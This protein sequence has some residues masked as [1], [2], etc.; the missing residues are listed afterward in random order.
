MDKRLLDAPKDELKDFL[1][2]RFQMR[3]R[4]AADTGT[5]ESE[6]PDDLPLELWGAAN[7]GLRRRIIQATRELIA[8]VPGEGWTAEAVD[9]LASFVGRAEIF[10]VTGDLQTAVEHGVWLNAPDDGVRCHT[11][12]LWALLGL[13]WKGTP[14]FWRQLSQPVRARYPALALRGL[15]ASSS[16]ADAFDWLPILLCDEAAVHQVLDV[17]SSLTRRVG[18]EVVREHLRAVRL[19]LSSEV[20]AKLDEWFEAYGW[21]SLAVR[22]EPAP[23]EARAPLRFA[24][25]LAE[26]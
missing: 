15:L 1:R 6:F 13:G 19:R 18:T 24:P 8:E 3:G 9:W 2:G 21:G 7:E 5:R 23:P 22:W 26:R 14:E 11:A 12:A 16:L 20:R 25:A 4:W 17:L 10:E